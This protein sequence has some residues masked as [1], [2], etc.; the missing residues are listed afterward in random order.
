MAE[1]HCQK[2]CEWCGD[3]FDSLAS[4]GRKYCSLE[5]ANAAK[6]TSKGY[7]KGR[8]HISYHEP[9]EWRDQ[10]REASRKAGRPAKRGKRVWLVCGVTNMYLGLDGLLGIIRYTLK[11][12]PFDG[13]IYAFCDQNCTM[14]KYL[15]WDGG[16]FCVSKRRAQSGSYPWPPSEAGLTLE[17]S[18]PEFEFLLRRSIV[19]FRTKN[20]REI[21]D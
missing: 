1:T 4:S 14:L 13:A 21:V 8:R 16:G 7:K 17:I 3:G 19:P 12:D 10:I 5:C 15:E 2:M 11:H 20:R 9:L 18:E 6:Y